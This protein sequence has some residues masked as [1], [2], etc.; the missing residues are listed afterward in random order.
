MVGERDTLDDLFRSKLQDA[1][2]DTTP[3]DWAAIAGRLPETK[4]IPL[5]KRWY[6]GAAAV[7]VLFIAGG[8]FYFLRQSGAETSVTIAEQIGQ[9]TSSGAKPEATPAAPYGVQ[10]AVAGQPPLAVKR[11]KTGKSVPPEMQ[12][13]AAEKRSGIPDSAITIKELEATATAIPL[14][15][16]KRTLIAA[17]KPVPIRQKASPSRKWNFGMGI[18]GLTQSAGDMVNTYTL[19]SSTVL[20]DER[21]LAI[22]ALSDAQQGIDPKTDIEH[23]T[24]ISFG[25]AA[26]RYLNNRLALQTGLTYSLHTSYWKTLASTYNYKTR[27]RMHFIGIPLSLVY[28]V[29]GWK[30]FQF[31]LSA[32]GQMEMNVARNLKYTNL[33]KDEPVEKKNESIRMKELLWSVNARAGVSYPIIPHISAF[34][35]VGAAYY[36][37]NGSTIETIYSEKDL[38]ISPQIGFRFGF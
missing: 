37:D 9:D 20:T 17:A 13:P 8:S 3:E 35:E 26:S 4:V 33:F 12:S 11:Q 27:Q 31:Y 21:L 7:A 1:E 2:A 25:L 14:T 38:S 32:G 36:F 23:C 16:S 5:R 6:Y 22:N 29:A 24:P 18:G 34:A 30:R 19:R 15:V 10:P 28:R